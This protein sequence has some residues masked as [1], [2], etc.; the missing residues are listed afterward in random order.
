LRSFTCTLDVFELFFFIN[1]PF[2]RAILLPGQGCY[3][4]IT[5][6]N[7]TASPFPTFAP[8]SRTHDD[9]E[10]PGRLEPSGVRC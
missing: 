8:L 10:R 7:L 2:S 4:E 1:L 9:R 5:R 3:K 6:E